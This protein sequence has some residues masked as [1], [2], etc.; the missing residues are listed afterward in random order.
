MVIVFKSFTLYWVLWLW[1][2]LFCNCLCW[3]VAYVCFA[4]WGFTC[5]DYLF[6]WGLVWFGFMID[7]LDIGLGIKLFCIDVFLV[8]MLLLIAFVA[9]WVVFLIYCWFVCELGLFTRLLFCVLAYRGVGLGFGL[10][11][12]GLVLGFVVYFV[13]YW[14]NVC[15]GCRWCC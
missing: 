13:V 14:Y 1:A 7:C 5:C 11:V 4:V 9:Y 15:S 6:V 3:S 2:G 10:W 8:W 12:V